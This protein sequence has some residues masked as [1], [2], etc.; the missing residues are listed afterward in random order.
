MT[1]QKS[2]D[3]LL[4]KNGIIITLGAQGRVLRNH[5]ILCEGGRIKKIAGA[6][7]FKGRYK[8]VIDAS[9]K[10]VMPG[11]INAH[12][13]FYSTLVRG[14][15]KAKPSKDFKEVL[16][17]LW[18]RL[19]KQLTLDDCYYSA[20]IPL[21]DAIK[22]GT[23]TLIDH[24]ASPF[25]ARGSL[26]AIAD[27]V[28]KSGY[29]AHV[30][31]THDAR[32][33]HHHEETTKSYFRKFIWGLVLSIPLLYFMLFDFFLFLPGRAFILPYIGII[34]LVLTLPV[35]FIIGA[36]FYKGMWSSLRMKTFNMDSLIAIGTSTAF[37]YSLAQFIN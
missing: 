5:A 9:G 22:N 37:F 12:M 13:H 28:K 25:A 21:V 18:W 33:E 2:P 1:K 35:Q 7:A 17:N 8:K 31:G 20:M 34:S 26:D 30:A 14:L 24:H 23:T 11:F 15:G 19:D 27:A 16:D 6:A 29:H 10:V 4:I 36:D 3:T 32:T